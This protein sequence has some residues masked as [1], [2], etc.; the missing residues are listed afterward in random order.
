MALILPVIMCGGSGTRMWPL[1]RE[2]YPKQFLPLLGER[3]SFEE[4]LRMLARP[5][6][7]APPIAISNRDYRFLV[8]EQMQKAGVEGEI[9]LEPMRRDS[10]PAVAVAAEIAFRRAPDT[11]V[12]MLAADH[13]IAERDGFVEL[14]QRAARRRGKRAHRDAWRDARSRRNRLRLHPP[15]Q[16]GG[17]TRVRGRRLHRKARRGARKAIRRCGLSVELRQF[18]LP[19]GCHARGDRGVRTADGAGRARGRGRRAQAISIFSFW[20]PTP[21]RR[22]RRNPSTTR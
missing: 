10:G 13:S 9:V 22:R 12:A 3:S 7:F 14:C 15:R 16:A 11:V 4:A 19:R 18:L 5:S 20:T 17:R 1:S 8:G 6:I 21:S 2:S